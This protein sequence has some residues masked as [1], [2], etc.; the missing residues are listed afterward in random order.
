[1]MQEGCVSH[2]P[3]GGKDVDG[4]HYNEDEPIDVTVKKVYVADEKGEIVKEV[5]ADTKR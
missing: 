1:M 2:A 3:S 5:V 4:Y